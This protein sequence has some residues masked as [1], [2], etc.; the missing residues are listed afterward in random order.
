M[1]EGEVKLGTCFQPSRMARPLQYPLT[2]KTKPILPVALLTVISYWLSGCSTMPAHLRMDLPPQ[3]RIEGARDF[4]LE[5]VRVEGEWEPLPEKRDK[6]IIVNIIRESLASHELETIAIR[7]HREA[8]E[9]MEDAILEKG[10]F[11]LKDGDADLRLRMRL[12]FIGKDE[13]ESLPEVSEAGDTLWIRHACRSASADLRG[14]F[15]DPSG[16]VAA[17]INL[18]RNGSKHCVEGVRPADLPSKR[19]VVEALIPPLARQTAA[20]ISPRSIIVK[21]NVFKKGSDRLKQA[22]GSVKNQDWEKAQQLWRA[23]LAHKETKVRQRAAV[24]L[25][26][27]KERQG[28]LSEALEILNQYKSG[29]ESKAV[30]ILSQGIQ[31][32]IQQ[33]S[34]LAQWHTN[35]SR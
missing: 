4:S 27:A 9:A 12:E 29:P 11:Q 18:Q 26:I 5:R 32:R 8:R 21:R 7:A 16:T 25:A 19:H 28:E 23:D 34:E 6:G 2:M 33:E 14:E 30:S 31:F 3:I 10:W 1:K 35:R 20:L 24:N 15:L 22:A 17:T 13:W